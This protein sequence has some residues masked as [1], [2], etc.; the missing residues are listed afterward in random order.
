MFGRQ[1]L[2]QKKAEEM[3]YRDQLAAVLN[4]PESA[5]PTADFAEV[6]LKC[7]C[8][9]GKIVKDMS[10]PFLLQAAERV[11]QELEV[12]SESASESA[13]HQLPVTSHR[14]NNEQSTD[15]DDTTLSVITGS[16]SGL[17]SST[18]SKT[19]KIS[20][21]DDIWRPSAEWKRG[22][23][24]ASGKIPWST[25]EEELVYQGVLAHG[26]GNWALIRAN[27]L[28]NR[29]NVDIKDKWRTMKRQG[30]LNTLADKL[31]PL[32]ANCLY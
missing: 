5:K 31:G 17:Q 4:D 20:S 2:H 29:S 23:E 13:L 21:V 3:K 15:G 28:P 9:L 24:K 27:F 22:A 11:C 10:K 25:V 19:T 8:M 1:W 30:R 7:Q 32:P 26:V 6:I 12:E 18:G 14:E 16:A